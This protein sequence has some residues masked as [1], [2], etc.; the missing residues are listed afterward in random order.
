MRGTGWDGRGT[1]W[2]GRGSGMGAD[3]VPRPSHLYND[4]DLTIWATI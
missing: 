2:D 4:I 3:L 1:G